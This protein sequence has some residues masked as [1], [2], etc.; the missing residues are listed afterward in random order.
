MLHQI[1]FILAITIGAFF[2][3]FLLTEDIKTASKVF[4]YLGSIASILMFGSPLT[5]IV[6]RFFI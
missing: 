5:S 4:G 3:S 1:L 2:Y 6:S